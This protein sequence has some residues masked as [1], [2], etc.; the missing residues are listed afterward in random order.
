MVCHVTINPT[1]C[2]VNF[3]LNDDTWLIEGNNTPTLLF[4][5]PIYG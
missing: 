1:F 2:L 4:Q 3:H 5:A